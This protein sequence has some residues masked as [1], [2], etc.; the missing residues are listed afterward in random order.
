MYYMYYM[1]F[2]DFSKTIFALKVS[3]KSK[4]K[5]NHTII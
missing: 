2:D 3:F 5:K 1:Y 4:K